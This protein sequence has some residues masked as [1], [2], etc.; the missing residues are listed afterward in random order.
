MKKILLLMAAVMTL[1]MSSCTVNEYTGELETTWLFWVLLCIFI[2]MIII[3]ANVSSKKQE[4]IKQ[5]GE[6]L[7]NTANSKYHITAQVDGIQNSFKFIVDDVD[8]EVIILYPSSASKTIPYAD[9]MGVEILE[10]GSTVHSK[11]MMRTV[12][13]ALVGNF[14]AGGAGM[15]V[16]GLS[17]NSKQIKKVS[18]VTVVIKLRSLS[19]PSVEIVCFN[20]PEHVGSKEIKTDD[21]SVLGIEYREAAKSATR[22]AQLIGVI[23]DENDREQKQASSN[24][25]NSGTIESGH[26]DIDA[27][28]KLAS[29]KEKGLISNE[30]YAA[31]KAKIIK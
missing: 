12:G 22:I 21:D 14:V 3:G 25:A 2:A 11:S 23:V 30:E 5:K 7:N 28:E 4:E 10:N 19:E 1:V 29:L 26:S 20:A 9:I 16:G 18:S 6:N 27:L 24:H 17:G 15:I 31:M 13:G 8:K